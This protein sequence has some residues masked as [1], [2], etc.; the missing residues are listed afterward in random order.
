MQLTYW[1]F[2][3]VIRPILVV[4]Y[5]L[6]RYVLGHGSWEAVLRGSGELPYEVKWT[7]P[8]GQQPW[9]VNYVQDQVRGRGEQ[10]LPYD[11]L[12]TDGVAVA[13]LRHGAVRGRTNRHGFLCRCDSVHGSSHRYWRRAIERA[14]CVVHLCAS[15][16]CTAPEAAELH[17]G[18]SGVAP[19]HV[20]VDL[21][22]LAGR[23]SR[24][25]RE[26]EQTPRHDLSETESEE[27]ENPCQADAIG[28]KEGSQ[29]KLMGE[30]A[31]QSS[32]NE[33][34][35]DGLQASCQLCSTPAKKKSRRPPGTSLGLG[36]L[37][38]PALAT[39]NLNAP[40]AVARTVPGP[41]R[42]ATPSQLEA[43]G[44]SSPA[45]LD[46]AAAP[47]PEAGAEM[48][49]V[50]DRVLQGLTW[51]EIA[52]IP[53]EDLRRRAVAQKKAV[54][55]LEPEQHPPGASE[56][57]VEPALYAYLDS[58]MRGSSHAAALS[59]VLMGRG[60]H[61]EGAQRL[62]EAARKHWLQL[63]NDSPPS[64]RQYV[65]ELAQDRLQ[66]GQTRGPFR[67]RELLS[68]VRPHAMAGRMEKTGVVGKELYHALR[69]AGT[70]A[71]PEFPCNIQNRH[72]YGFAALQ[73]GGKTLATVP[74]YCLSAGDFPL[75]SEEDFD[76]FGGSPDL[77]LEK[78]GRYPNTLTSWFRAALREAWAFSCIF[79]EEYYAPLERAAS[80]LLRLGEQ[81]GYAWTATAVYSAWE[82][83]WARFCEEARELDRRVRR[84]MKDETPTFARLKFF[85]LSPGPDGQPWLQ[86]PGTFRLDDDTQYFC[87]DMLPRMQRQ[88][89]RACWTGAQKRSGAAPFGGDVQA[90]ARSEPGRGQEPTTVRQQGEV[91][92]ARVAGGKT[93]AERPEGR[94]TPEPP[95]KL[96]GLL[97]PSLHPRKAARSLDHRPKDAQGQYLCWDHLCH[98][99]CAKGG[100]CAHSR[101]SV[102]KWSGL[103]YSVQ[104]QL[105]RRGGLKG[106]KAKTAA[107]VEREFTRVRAEQA[108]KASAAKQEGIDTAR[109]AAKAKAK[110]G[111]GSRDVSRAGEQVD[112]IVD[113]LRDL[114]PTDQEGVLSELL[115]DAGKSWWVD[116][117]VQGATLERPS[118]PFKDTPRAE[119]MREI[120]A[121]ENRLGAYPEGLLGV[122]LRNRLLRLREDTGSPAQPEDVTRLLE[123]AADRG[124]PELAEAAAQLLEERGVTRKELPAVKLSPI[125]WDAAIGA[126][127]L[128]WEGQ[129]QWSM[130]D[131]RD[132]LWLDTPACQALGFADASAE[133]KQCLL[134]HVAAAYLSKPGG[135]LPAES[136]VQ[137]QALSWRL[138]WATQARVAED[139]LGPVPSRLSQAEAD[140][141]VFHHDL[142]YFGHDRDYR[143]L[144]A[145]PLEVLCGARYKGDAASTRWVLIH[146]GHMRLLRPDCPRSPP[147][148]S[149]ELDAIGW[150]AYLEA[151]GDAPLLLQCHVCHPRRQPGSFRTG[152]EAGAFG[153]Q[154]VCAV[155]AKAGVVA[156]SEPGPPADVAAA[157]W[158]TRA[159][160]PPA[161]TPVPLLLLGEPGLR[162]PGTAVALVRNDGDAHEAIAYLGEGGV[163][164]L[165]LLP[166]CLFQGPPHQ[167]WR[168]RCVVEAPL[169]RRAWSDKFARAQLAGALWHAAP[170]LG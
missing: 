73:L 50:E 24:P 70:Q 32:S 141:R 118:E 115:G 72:S 58:R 122:Y 79:G 89:S 5:A 102:P 130:F 127:T 17:V 133:P 40:P 36:G 63:P 76:N 57:P 15:H 95:P 156:R 94:P 110:S 67:A 146:K 26:E 25:G 149:R 66:V 3:W 137:A 170:P 31:H 11:L 45:R 37:E 61:P 82:E 121:D 78:K 51:E 147:L 42:N 126:G 97:G 114:H 142:L 81:H 4:V 101:K 62:K 145:H 9:A 22:E 23:V 86:L 6:T 65:W 157:D 120:D 105:L 154:E 2:V 165:W 104:L 8:R 90:E 109:A 152:R 20:D 10:Q 132:Q 21:N 168:R 136:A 33:L 166:D 92:G 75:T 60:N 160:L 14:Q 151:A 35:W 99:G 155:S 131:Y 39:R 123:E 134:L 83:L 29:I 59:Q 93:E 52:S 13:R 30:D 41:R 91:E 117:D 48:Q 143:T 124:G 164:L 56:P 85:A 116:T 18:A 16:P 153:L 84:E 159:G 112:H 38:P 80:H 49:A 53:D 34:T 69:I 43:R 111:P 144:V 107:D 71:R 125:N 139:S 128:S 28:W 119:T 162:P 77:K 169:Y 148:G 64:L 74:D 100:A 19:Q 113:D 167:L 44:L 55:T 140:V 27:D 87:T 47:R 54:T 129:G 135:P 12:V 163:D 158:A 150:E 103:D 88:L 46:H 138:W 7:G 161:G 106:S 68:Q 98:R 1:S 96:L 108:A